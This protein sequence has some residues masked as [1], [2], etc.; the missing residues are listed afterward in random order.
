MRDAESARKDVFKALS[1]YPANLA[2]LSLLVEI[3]IAAEAYSE[4]RKVIEQIEYVH[5]NSRALL[6]GKGYL[7]L[8]EGNA[9][10]ASPL[11]KDS[12]E[13][14]ADDLLGEAIYQAYK[15]L[16][17]NEAASEFLIAWLDRIPSSTVATIHLAED[18][19]AAG[20]R[21]KAIKAYDALLAVA[22]NS[23][24]A[25]NNL[26]SLYLEENNLDQALLRAQQAFEQSPNNGFIADTYGWVLFKMGRNVDA[27]RILA[28]A[29]ER[30]NDPD[31]KQH[32]EEVKRSI[33][34]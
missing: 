14:Q 30:S 5:P 1:Y 16:A 31:I 28:I 10:V 25:L 21:S 17:Q 29:V 11:L 8:A 33:Q 6:K 20:E 15:M 24:A 4:V 2:L 7:A 3:E 13:M 19:A 32:F 23:A 9:E 26:A 12:W 22:P 27:E 34:R 18:F